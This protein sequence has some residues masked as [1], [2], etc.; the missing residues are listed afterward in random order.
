ME[1]KSV[2]YV[3]VEIQIDVKHLV[4]TI[5]FNLEQ[6]EIIYLMGTI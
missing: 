3:F 2:L 5:V 4:K 6:T 1:I